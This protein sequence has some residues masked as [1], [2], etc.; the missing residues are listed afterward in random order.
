MRLID[1]QELLEQG[2]IT[3]GLAEKRTANFYNRKK[4]RMSTPG[5]KS[6]SRILKLYLNST[7]EVW[8]VPCP[9]CGEYQPLEFERL[10]LD[11][12]EMACSHCGSF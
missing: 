3:V 11:T 2:E 12:L 7:Q 10:D 6:N 4:V 9:K 5:L 1:I 8:N